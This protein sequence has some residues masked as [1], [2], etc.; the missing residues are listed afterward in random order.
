MMKNLRELAREYAQN[1]IDRESYRNSRRKLIQGICAGEIEV[2]A[3]EYLAPLETFSEE[4]DDTTENMITEIVQQAKNT[5]SAAAE[6]PETPQAKVELKPA[7]S[8][9]E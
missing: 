1:N 4:L 3:H 8:P 5:E 6:K 9:A 2:K 7:P